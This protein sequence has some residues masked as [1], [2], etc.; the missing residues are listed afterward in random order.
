MYNSD[1]YT[2]KINMLLSNLKVEEVAKNMDL[3]EI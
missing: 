2:C 3:Q 1:F